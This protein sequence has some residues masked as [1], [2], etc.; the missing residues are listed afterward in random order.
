MAMPL[1]AAMLNTVTA[2]ARGMWYQELRPF[3]SLNLLQSCV[4]ITPILRLFLVELLIY[5][6]DYIHRKKIFVIRRE[7]PAAAVHPSPLSLVTPILR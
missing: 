1:P 2:V 5:H 4:P 7:C 3:I 6:P